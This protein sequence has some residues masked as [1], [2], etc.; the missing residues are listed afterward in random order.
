MSVFPL[1]GLAECCQIVSGA[2]PSTSVSAYW[3]GEVCWA[4]PKDLSDLDGHYISD[5]PRKLTTEGLNSCAA[6]ILPPGSVLFSSRAPIGHVAI[7]AVPMATNQGFKSFVPFSEK[8]DAKFLFHWLRANRF[9]IEGLGVGATFKEVSKATV[10]KIKIPL[11]PLP[12]QRRIAAILDQADA[13]RAKRRE[14]LA[15]LDQLQQA[16]FMD[17]FGDPATNP[18]RWPTSTLSNVCAV[19]GEYGAGVAAIEF[20]PSLPR[21]VRITDITDRGE[22]NGRPV[23]P[24]GPPQDWT[25]Y[26]LQAGDLLFARSGAT[27]GKTYLYKESDGPC[28]FAGYL[29]RF[30]PNPNVALPSYIFS[31]TQT[32]A[33]R[34]WVAARQRVVAQPNI[35]ATQYGHELVLPVPPL[36]LQRE[37]CDLV[38][39]LDRQHALM[40]GSQTANDALFASLQHRAFRGEL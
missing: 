11:P 28:V 35:N 36:A 12:E 37:F 29:I 19:S 30:R 15:Q 5:T 2:T 22:L 14:A 20:D 25:A 23:S 9:Y 1:T 26:K 8:I 38:D 40:Q 34:T 16:I 3:D 33:Y 13:L 17:M 24:G 21:Y 32:A 7:N 27:V 39:E 31:F 10:S 4:T 6:T 18:K